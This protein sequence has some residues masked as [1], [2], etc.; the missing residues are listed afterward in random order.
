M[1][2]KHC[3]KQPMTRN[4]NHITYNNGDDGMVCEIVLPALGEVGLVQYWGEIGRL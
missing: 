2:V 1:W 4:G 3:H